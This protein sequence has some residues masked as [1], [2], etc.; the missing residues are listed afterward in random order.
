[1]TEVPDVT[2][3]SIISSPSC[4][5]TIAFA[6]ESPSPIPPCTL[7]SDPSTC[8]NGFSAFF[9][10]S[11]VL[12]IGWLAPQTNSL[13]LAA[14]QFAV[15][16]VFSLITAL[17]IETINFASIWQAIIPILYGGLCSVGIAYT[18]QIIAQRDAHPAHS[19]IIMSLEGLFAA[20]GGWLV[21]GEVLSMRALL[22]CTLMLAGM[23]FSQISGIFGAKKPVS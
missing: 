10:S 6:R 21:L 9:W 19:A 3:L 14:A 8:D 1:V 13:K 2:I 17:L 22:G 11:H 15:C 12:L 23:F 20:I 7:V 5:S 18:L 4:N 16:S